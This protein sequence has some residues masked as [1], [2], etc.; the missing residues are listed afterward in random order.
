[1]NSTRNTDNRISWTTKA[2]NF[3]LPLYEEVKN[4]QIT[5]KSREAGFVQGTQEACNTMLTMIKTK[6]GMYGNN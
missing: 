1:M 6:L 4:L 5:K 2:L 3:V